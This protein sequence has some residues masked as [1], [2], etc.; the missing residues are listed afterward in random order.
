MPDEPRDELSD[1]PSNE[2]PDEL[3]YVWIDVPSIRIG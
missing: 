1:E 3:S 2:L